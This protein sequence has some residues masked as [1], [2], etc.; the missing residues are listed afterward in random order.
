MK[1]I[2]EMEFNMDAEK[3]RLFLKIFIGLMFVCAAVSG[4]GLYK[5]MSG[6]ADNIKEYENLETY[7]SVETDTAKEPVEEAKAEEIVEEITEDI[8]PEEVYESKI[9]VDFDMDFIAL[10]AINSDF[11]GWVYY[12]PIDLSYPIVTDKGND[13]YENHSFEGDNNSAGAIFMDYLCKTDFTGF[14]SVI[15]GHNMRNGTMFGS[16]NDIIDNKK[17]LEQDDHFYVFTEKEAMMYKIVSAYYT[18]NDSQTYD[19]KIDYTLE[20]MEK[21][22][23][24]ME[25]ASIYKDQEFFDNGV[26]EDTEL[27]T[28]STCHGLHTNKRTVIHGL[29]VAREPRKTAQDKENVEE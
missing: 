3:K 21:Y 29:L 12:E 22:V 28:M 18:T 5:T 10:K 19:L 14:N 4:Y 7:V 6:Y 25:G 13:Y 26:T 24:Y 2:G 1:V 23:E 27:C 16:L 15:Y 20:D 8:E 9:N 17:Y 11:V